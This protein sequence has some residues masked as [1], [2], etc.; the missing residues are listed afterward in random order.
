MRKGVSKV[1]DL[2][3]GAAA[4]GLFTANV[5]YLDPANY[6]GNNNDNGPGTKEEP[7]DTTQ[8][9][10]D[11]CTDNLGDVIIRMRGYEEVTT[12]V[13][14]NK[15]GISIIAH[16]YGTNRRQAED[17]AVHMTGTDGPAG[18]ISKNCYVDGL[19]FA[20]NNVTK[21][22]DGRA[23]NAGTNSAAALYFLGEGG[24]F[25]GGFS[26]FKSCRFPDWITGQVWGIEFGAGASNLI[27]RCKFEG[28]SAGIVFGGT[29]NNNPV[30]TEIEHC[31]FND[32][33]NGVELLPGTAQDI[34][35]HA[36][37]FMDVSGYSVDTNGNG[38]NGMITD[39]WHEV[40][41]SSAY[42]LSIADMKTAGWNPVGNHYIE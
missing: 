17:F 21:P 11:A 3:D 29:S 36:N 32:L 38:G 15:A 24:G 5:F 30:D 34:I 4:L 18:I 42:D 14:F 1:E 27:Q 31:V 22:G 33:T 16:Q 23:N 39:N 20:T 37:H 13:L 41:N 6:T 12:P 40:A 7:F 2:L 10:I 19:V 35:I 9:A 26:T 28:L 25:N 8:A